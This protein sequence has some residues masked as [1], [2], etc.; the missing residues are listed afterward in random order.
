MNS[1]KSLRLDSNAQVS[2]LRNINNDKI[3]NILIF[4]GSGDSYVAG[5]SRNILLI[6]KANV[7]A[8]LIYSIP[9]CPKTRPIVLFRSQAKQKPLYRCKARIAGRDARQYLLPMKTAS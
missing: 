9:S 1:I 7:I 6:T 5:L 3:S 4:V 2:E 8:L